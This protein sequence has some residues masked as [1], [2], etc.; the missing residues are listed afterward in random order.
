VP[1]TGRSTSGRSAKQA[2]GAAANTDSHDEAKPK[3]RKTRSTRAEL[4]KRTLAIDVLIGD[5]CGGTRRWVALLTEGLAVRKILTH[6]GHDTEP[7]PYGPT[8]RPTH[9]RSPWRIVIH[10]SGC[11]TAGDGQTSAAGLGWA[12]RQKPASGSPVVVLEQAAKAFSASDIAYARKVGD[13][14]RGPSGRTIRPARPQQGSEHEAAGRPLKSSAER[15]SSSRV[16]PRLCAARKIRG[17]SVDLLL[18]HLALTWAL[19]GLTWTIQ[20]VQ[21]PSFA[22]VGAAEFARFHDYHCARITWIVAPLMGGELLTGLALFWAGPA[23][24]GAG[25]MWAGLA[26]IALNWIWT[27]CVAMPLHARLRDADR[28]PTQSLVRANWV[29][30]AAWSARGLWSLFAVRAALGVA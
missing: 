18:L 28:R 22:L 29:R 7:T 12:G 4:R 14:D 19:V 24:L 23:S 8:G 10:A 9:L 20:W 13:L 3:I 16:H 17:T 25:L 21:Y 1:G 11:E 5:H 2:T 30:T 27:A 26:L 6:L 15:E